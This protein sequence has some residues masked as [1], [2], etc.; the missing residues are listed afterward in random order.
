MYINFTAR[1]A[2]A[3][4][5]HWYDRRDG[6]DVVFELRPDLGEFYITTTMLRAGLKAKPIE[7]KCEEG[8]RTRST[9]TYQ[10]EI[11]RSS[12]EY[13]FDLIENVFRDRSH[14]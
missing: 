2:P 7:L 1:Q 13:I 5:V 4:K 11:S 9:M 12:D 3:V 8:R 14:E 10:Y 6:Y